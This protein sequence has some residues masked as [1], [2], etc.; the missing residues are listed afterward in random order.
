MHWQ[1]WIKVIGIILLVWILSTVNWEQT[2]RALVKLDPAY[3]VGYFVCFVAMTLVRT[4][5][6]RL[7]LTR[8]GHPL[9]LKDC[10]IAVLEP[11]F[12]GAVTPGRLGE[13]TRVGYIQAQGLPIQEAIS[14]VMVERLIDMFVLL[15]FGTGGMIYIFAPEPY[16]IGSG[17]V[18]LFGLSF[19]LVAIRLYDL[20]FQ[21][22]QKHLKW[23]LCWEPSSWA[24]HRQ[25]MATSFHLV[26]KRTAMPIFLL[27]LVYT[28]LTLVQVF[29]LAKAFGFEADYLVV[30]F[31]Y[32]VS[33]LVALLPISVGGLGTREATYIMIMG[34]EGIM[35]EQAL[36]FSLLDGFIFGVLMLLILLIPV[37]ATRLLPKLLKGNRGL[38]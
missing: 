34:R 6:L 32:A 31:A 23:M 15:V 26:M 35:K 37:W 16:R 22:L 28:S 30:I 21:I 10:Y 13:F 20:T 1:N 27:G 18:I 9:S 29:L 24:R 3:M 7:A 2:L 33:T 5:R 12:M 17:L 11:A 36:L 25:A 8:L 14:L 38:K 19:C 4:L